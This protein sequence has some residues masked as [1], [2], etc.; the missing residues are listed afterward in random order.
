MSPPQG[1]WYVPLHVLFVMFSHNHLFPNTRHCLLLVAARVRTSVG[2]VAE[3]TPR[4]RQ[5]HRCYVL[6]RGHGGCGT[7]KAQPQCLE[8]RS[9]QGMPHVVVRSQWMTLKWAC[10]CRSSVRLLPLAWASTSPMCA[11]SS[12]TTCRSHSHTT[13]KNLAVQ[14]V[15]VKHR[16]ASCFTIMGTRYTCPSMSPIANLTDAA[17]CLEHL[18]SMF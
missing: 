12:T 7:K 13:I 14:D 11:T 6:P 10:E 1:L 4:S 18:S 3:D 16:S 8:Q 2:E 9:C 15:T 17:L 5:A